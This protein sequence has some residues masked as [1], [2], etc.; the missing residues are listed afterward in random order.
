MLGRVLPLGDNS[1]PEGAWGEE[2][3]VYVVLHPNQCLYC[4]YI[5]TSISHSGGA[6]VCYRSNLPIRH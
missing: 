6:A 2:A 1:C 4:T 5:K 3:Y